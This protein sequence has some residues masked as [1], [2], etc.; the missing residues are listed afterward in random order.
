MKNNMAILIMACMFAL[1][2]ALPVQAIEDSEGDGQW[3]F[4][5]P[6]EIQDVTMPALTP[7]LAICSTA[8]GAS[9]TACGSAASTLSTRAPAIVYSLG[10]DWSS[11]SS[12][13]QVEN[14]GTTIGG[15]PSGASY[16]IAANAVFVSRGK[17]NKPGAE[18]DDVVSWISANALFHSLVAAGRLP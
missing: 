6:G 15:G 12:P 14:S 10:S 3:D 5:T 13:D 1:T 9:A 7:D 2:L 8:S 16:P 11:F 18:F 4:T 17:S